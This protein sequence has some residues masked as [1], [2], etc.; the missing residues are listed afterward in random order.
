[1]NKYFTDKKT[2]TI[3]TI[4]NNVEIP[5]SDTLNSFIEDSNYLSELYEKTK[6]E[7]KEDFVW[8]FNHGLNKHLIEANLEVYNAMNDYAK[9]II[10]NE[11]P[12]IV[13]PLNQFSVSKI[14]INNGE[15][16]KIFDI[17]RTE[18]VVLYK[19]AKKNIELTNRMVDMGNKINTSLSNLKKD[20]IENKPDLKIK[21]AEVESLF[22]DFYELE[23]EEKNFMKSLKDV[24]LDALVKN[25]VKY[26]KA[27]EPL[28][29]ELKNKERIKNIRSL[30]NEKTTE[31]NI[32]KGL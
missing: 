2:H 19:L 15:I 9:K 29:N 8:L 17:T 4:E 25:F 30:I 24:G 12:A 13:A 18:P 14:N 28:I 10:S 31:N 22:P 7:L 21:L 32:K 5:Y 23:N 6:D 20:N 3:G 11:N 26:L 16:N 1:M 27:A